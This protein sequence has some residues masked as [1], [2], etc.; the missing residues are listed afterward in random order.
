MDVVKEI[1]EL[2][3]EGKLKPALKKFNQW[4]EQNDED[5]YN[6]SILLLSRYNQLMRNTALNLI[7]ESEAQRNHNRLSHALLTSLND[8]PQQSKLQPPHAGVP[9]FAEPNKKQTKKLFISYARE[10]REWVNK[11]ERHLAAL[12]RRGLI[13]SWDDSRIQ[14]GT[15]WND[16]IMTEMQKADIFIFMVSADFLASEF[17]YKYEVPAALQRSQADS[18]V[19]VVPVILRPCNWSMESY[20]RFQALPANAK[21]ISS[22]ADPDEAFVDVVQGLAKM[23]E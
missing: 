19:K 14:P 9:G 5:L 2:I 8:V 15:N 23:L 18:A 16:S 10:D 12:Q 4:A 3:E 17:I 11:L 6:S 22:W 7:S 13:D 1:Q 21:P 20:A